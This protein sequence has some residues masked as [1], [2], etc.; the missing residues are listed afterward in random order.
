M[1]TIVPFFPIGH[2]A[3]AITFE[4]PNPAQRAVLFTSIFLSFTFDY[5]LRQ[6]LGGTNLSLF[7]LEQLPMP[8]PELISTF[9]INYKNNSGRLDEFLIERAAKLIVTS[10]SLKCVLDDLNIN[11]SP[12]VWHEERKQLVWEIDAAVAHLYGLDKD[13]YEHIFTE[14]RIQKDKDISEFGAFRTRD[15]CLELFDEITL[16]K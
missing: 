3:S 10:N 5:I 4:G 11:E 7:I 14:F 16:D 2:S 8:T 13:M 15:K 1:G 12:Y 9:R 6:K